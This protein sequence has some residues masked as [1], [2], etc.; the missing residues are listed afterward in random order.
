MPLSAEDIARLYRAEARRMAA[1]LVRATHDPEVAMDLVGETFATAIRD[2]RR[3]RGTTEA[4]ES[5]WLYAISRHLLT[6][7]YRRGE[8][9]KRAMARLGVERPSI[10]PEELARL[11]ELGGLAQVRER[12]ARSLQALPTDQREAVERR[13]VGEWSYEEIAAS[14]Q[15]SVEAARAR[16]SRGLRT[17]AALLDEPTTEVQADAR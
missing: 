3:F 5:A 4:E 12:V 1:F 10:E 7:W 14:C 17:L 15:I 13:V 11:V 6:S 2:G 8:V 9:E 16:V